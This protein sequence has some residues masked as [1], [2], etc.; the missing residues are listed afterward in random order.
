MTQDQFSYYLLGLYAA[1]LY[2]RFVAGMFIRDNAPALE[3]EK[4]MGLK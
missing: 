2:I 1:A 3:A 4:R